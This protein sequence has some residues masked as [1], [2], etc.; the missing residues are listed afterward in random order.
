MSDSATK[1]SSQLGIRLNRLLYRF[2]KNWYKF[3]GGFLGLLVGGVFAAPIL[4]NLGL[5]GPASVLYTIYAP[6][7]HQ[8]AFRSLFIGGEQIAYPRAQ[9]DSGLRPF[10]DYVLDDPNFAESYD[11]WYEFSYRQP[12]DRDLV[13][14]DLTQF[15]L[16]LQLAA[17]AFPGNSQMGYKTAVCQ[18]D[19]AIYSGMLIFLLVYLIPAVRPRLRPLPFLLFVIMGVGP[20][21]LDGVSQ[22][23]SYPPF[24]YWPTRETLPQLR[25]ITGFLF[26]FMG[27]WLAFPLL[28]AN[29]RDIQRQIIAKFHKANIP[30]V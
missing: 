10:E 25:L 13:M 29:M 20:I 22:L 4:M 12:L 30:L 6:L 1:P 11:Y 18:R 23:L 24:Q 28:D 2:A 7:C 21:G 14:G 16:P 8:F 17:K 19:M 5:P 9:A 27:G 15:T 26:G 3:I